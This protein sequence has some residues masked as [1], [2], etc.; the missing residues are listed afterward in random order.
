MKHI[1]KHSKTYS[2]KYFQTKPFFPEQSSVLAS[3]SFSEG[4]VLVNSF[5]EVLTKIE[6][7]RLFRIGYLLK[8]AAYAAIRP[9][10]RGRPMAHMAAH[11]TTIYTVYKYIDIEMCAKGFFFLGVHVDLYP[12]MHEDSLKLEYDI[13]W[14][15]NL[16]AQFRTVTSS[17][18]GGC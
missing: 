2:N 14:F 3:T 10:F 15:K 11:T 8:L 1:P 18:A 13:L 5:P 7:P 6:N 17:N 16:H 12:F 4:F 9:E